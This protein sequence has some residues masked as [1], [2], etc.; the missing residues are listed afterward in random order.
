ML[1]SRKAQCQK[2][3][4]KN[5]NLHKNVRIELEELNTSTAN[6]SHQKTPH[7]H[8]HDLSSRE[9]R[10]CQCL[11]AAGP[12]PASPS[13]LEDKLDKSPHCACCRTFSN[14]TFKNSKTS[15]SWSRY[16]GK[17]SARPN[18]GSRNAPLRLYNGSHFALRRRA[19]VQKWPAAHSDAASH[20]LSELLV[21]ISGNGLPRKILGRISIIM[22]IRRGLFQLPE[23]GPG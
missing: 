9:G 20:R 1:L 6:A 18:L 17:A 5:C 23:K 11:R 14:M 16:Q 22:L 10:H 3:D 13:K 19:E 15:C 2:T 7:H 8:Y 21:T 12:A 4:V